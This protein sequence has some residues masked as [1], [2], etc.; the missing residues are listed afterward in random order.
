MITDYTGLIAE[1]G[2]ATLELG[3]NVQPWVG[4]LTWNMDRDFAAWRKLKGGVSKVF[5]FPEVK[6]KKSEMGTVKGAEGRRGKP[7]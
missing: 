4:P 7:E 2:N 1:R 6:G 5:D 3:W